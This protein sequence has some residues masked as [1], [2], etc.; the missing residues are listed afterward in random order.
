MLFSNILTPEARSYSVNTRKNWVS[1]NAILHTLWLKFRTKSFI[2]NW[3]P[4]IKTS[5]HFPLIKALK[6][7]CWKY[8]F[9]SP[10]QITC[11]AH[12]ITYCSKNEQGMQ[13]PIDFMSFPELSLGINSIPKFEKRN[14]ILTDKKM[15]ICCDYNKNYRA[16]Y[17]DITIFIVKT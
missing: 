7:I 16:F 9:I 4:W 2:S 15:N 10:S 8:I 11:L 3:F 13:N 17:K 6:Y 5:R 12:F 1:P 14:K